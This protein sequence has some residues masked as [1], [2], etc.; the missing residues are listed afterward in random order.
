MLPAT[1]QSIAAKTAKAAMSK[2]RSTIQTPICEDI[3]KPVRLLSTR[4]EEIWR[5]GTPPSRSTYT[6]SSR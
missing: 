5:V 2:M 6:P 4:T 3:V 1:K